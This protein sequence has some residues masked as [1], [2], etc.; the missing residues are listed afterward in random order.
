[1][2]D[3]GL[4]LRRVWMLYPSK[5]GPRSPQLPK[6]TGPRC[7]RVWMSL[8]CALL[9]LQHEIIT[10]QSPLSTA[11]ACQ[12]LPLSHRLDKANK[13]RGALSRSLASTP[14]CGFQVLDMIDAMLW[15]PRLPRIKYARTHTVRP[16]TM[17]H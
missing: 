10:A 5:L 13:L 2:Q 11:I 1:V 3:D 12:S 7:R 15:D 6:L 14:R 4:P 9:L 16:S 17:R 8:I